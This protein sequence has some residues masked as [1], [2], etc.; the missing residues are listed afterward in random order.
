ME[1]LVKVL[2]N[3]VALVERTLEPTVDNKTI[4]VLRS[5][6]SSMELEH[7]KFL[8]LRTQNRASSSLIFLIC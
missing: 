5:T 3:S 4:L 1:L 2:F 7:S 8:E 6:W